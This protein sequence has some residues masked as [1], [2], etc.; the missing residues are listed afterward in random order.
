MNRSDLF[1]MALHNLW[2]RKSRTLFNIFGIVVSCSLLLL[3]FAGTRGA[4]D[5]MMNL[6]SQSDFAMHFAIRPG[7]N[8]KDA[9]KAPKEDYANLGK[10]VSKDRMDRIREKLEDEWKVKNRPL[11]RM[12]LDK[13]DEI[14]KTPKLV[15]VIPG[16]TI[17]GQMTLED[18]VLSA[19]AYPFSAQSSGLGDRIIAGSKPQPHSSRG[20]IWMDEYRAWRLGYRTDEQLEKLVGQKVKLRFAA[21]SAKLSPGIR[22]FANAFGIKN[23]SDSELLANAF[24]RLFSDIERTGLDELEKK[25][26]LKAAEKLGLD[27]K[28]T[29]IATSAEGEPFIYREF[30]IAGIFQSARTG[31]RSVFQQ[32]RVNFGNDLLIDWR[33]FQAI[34]KAT[35]PNRIY[36]YSVASVDD[37]GDLREAIEHVEDNGFETQ[38]A[39]SVLDRVEEELG[40]VRLIVAS[41][42]FVIL[43]IAS[44]GIMNTVIIAVMER[45]PEFG[46][47]KAV[48]ATDSDIRRL[49]LIEAALTGILGA[50]V[51]LGA[52]FLV[53]AAISRFAR[54]YIEKQIRQ[55]FDFSIFVYS[56]GDLLIIAAIA[57]GICM[58]SSLLPSRRAAKLDPVIAMK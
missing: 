28:P 55:E 14:R 24:R 44:V 27:S 4:R 11:V 22:R 43:L 45:T 46:I 6:F 29:K 37:A 33:D 8:Q 3:T 9:P 5:G 50:I 47:M 17:N 53:D 41:I 30:D 1:L 56:F 54:S 26:V 49:M 23:I 31:E 15:S 18:K 21:A 36:Y 16:R 57:V 10:G 39:L 13:L 20:K 7:R 51:S 40:K 58:L 25:A 2:S 12:S 38:S 42:A 48:G 34:E 19:R 35:N 32:A 52:A